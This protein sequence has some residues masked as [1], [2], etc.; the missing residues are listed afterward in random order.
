MVVAA[1]GVLLVLQGWKSRIPNFDMLTT[2]DAAQALVESGRLPDRGVL[3]SFQSF[4]P[5][6]AAWLMAPG[7]ALFRDSRLFEYIGSLGLYVGTIVGIFLL[8]RR[9]VG[10]AGAVLAAALYGFSALG[11]TAG[12]TLWQRY[13]IH[14]FTVWTVY[15]T[16][17]WT[18]ENR[19]IWLAAALLT[20]AVGIY[21]FLEM[22]PIIFALPV[23]WVLRR[24]AIHVGP[25]VA[26][27]AL[28]AAVWYPYVVFEFDR[29]FVDLRSQILRQSIRQ[30]NFSQSWCDPSIAPAAWGGDA[31]GRLREVS[32]APRSGAV[33][34]RRWLSDRMGITV[35]E[36][37]LAT[38]RYHPAIPAAARVLLMATLV[39]MIGLFG[40]SS[41]APRSPLNPQQTWRRRLFWLAVGAAL[42]A[43]AGNELVFAHVVSLD[44]VLEASSISTIREIQAT[45]L[46]TAVIVLASRRAMATVIV[47]AAE[48]WSARDDSVRAD[49]LIVSLAVPWLLLFLV[50]D[51]ENRFWWLWPLQVIPLAASVT[52]VASRL[53][54]PFWLARLGAAALVLIVAANTVLL[55]RIDSWAHQGW[56]GQDAFEIQAVDRIARLMGETGQRQASIGYEVD[57]WRFMAESN[58]ADSRYK[59]GADFDLLLKYRHGIV[60]QNRCAEGVSQ[61]DTYRIVQIATVKA[62]NPDG[63]NRIVATREPAFEPTPAVGIYQ[64]LQQQPASA[65][66]RTAPKQAILPAG[67]VAPSNK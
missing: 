17:R 24:P 33:S 5:P 19:P 59:V 10:Q 57:I 50:A 40:G 67:A 29:G 62:A 44:G 15:W 64:V 12:T 18:D 43:L 1:T 26:V 38:F 39:G 13:P 23:I 46:I 58:V 21:V 30:V 28:T 4:T 16:A 3:T 25:L 52:Y 8:A 51:G 35:S 49:A 22:L 27:A 14:C 6:G 54:L 56:S 65:S 45:L 7:V 42:V 53:A 36:L 20:W 11:L 31:A 61:G 55:G 32:A 9:Y 37:L 63:N 2:I 47:R 41:F 34:V 60:N 66:A 48:T